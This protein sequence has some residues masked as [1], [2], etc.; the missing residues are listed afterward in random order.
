MLHR[1]EAVWRPQLDKLDAEAPALSQAV[2]DA[3]A[4]VL[5]AQELLRL[6]CL[7]ASPLQQR[8][9]LSIRLGQARHELA[10]LDAED[11]DDEL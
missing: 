11:E 3:Q 10:A 1:Q 7:A 4:A 2:A 9:G 6:A 8:E 5:A